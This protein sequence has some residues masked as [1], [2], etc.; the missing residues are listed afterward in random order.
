MYYISFSSHN[1]N[2]I[3]TSDIL[4]NIAV[5]SS[6]FNE[7]F[8]YGFSLSKTNTEHPI[9]KCIAANEPIF[10]RNFVIDTK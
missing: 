6:D 2:S 8:S 3:S 5:S 10:K 9:Q 4:S 1:Y 7:I